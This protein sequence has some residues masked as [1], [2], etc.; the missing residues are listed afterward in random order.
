MSG[1]IKKNKA[2]IFGLHE[3]RMITVTDDWYPCFDNN[4]ICLSIS[5]HKIGKEYRVTLS[6]FGKDDFGVCMKH[7]SENCGYEHGLYKHWK[8]YIYDRVPDGVDVNWFYEHGF[9]HD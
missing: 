9:Y 8:K 4:T 3:T 2:D 5:I 7:A 6:A 1:K